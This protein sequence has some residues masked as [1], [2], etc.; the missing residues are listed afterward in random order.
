VGIL[1]SDRFG[2][3]SDLN[4]NGHLHYPH[5]IDRSLNESTSDKIRKYR[6]RSSRSDDHITDHGPTCWVGYICCLLWINKVRPKGK[7]CIWVSVRWKTKNSKWGIYMTRRH[8]VGRVPR[9]KGEINKREIHECDG[10]AH[11]PDTMADPL[12]PKVTLKPETSPGCHRPLPYVV[13]KTL[14]WRSDHCCF[15]RCILE[16]KTKVGNTAE[17]GPTYPPKYRWG[18]HHTE[19]THPPITRIR[20][21]SVWPRDDDRPTDTQ[22][23]IQSRNPRQGVV[24]HCL[25]SRRRLCTEEVLFRELNL[26]LKQKSEVPYRN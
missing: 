7:T 18:S 8:W 17:K 16:T 21:T 13:K 1:K 20:W 6:S 22:T 10:W 24:D 5:D 25:T 12:T 14:H 3:S 4:L 19:I 11:D 2:S 26:K 15:A 9:D 23:D